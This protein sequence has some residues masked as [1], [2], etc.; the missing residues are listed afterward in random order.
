MHDV[1]VAGSFGLGL[2][3]RSAYGMLEQRLGAEGLSLR[4]YSVFACLA[5][6][7]GLSQQQVCER[8]QVDRSDMVRLID[9]LERNGL[10]TRS[11]DR[12]DRRRISSR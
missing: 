12:V 11:R 3:H 6:Q 5:E 8:A 9:E 10:V 2:L 4:A 7:D 1:V